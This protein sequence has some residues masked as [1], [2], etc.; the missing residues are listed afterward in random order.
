[1]KKAKFLFL[2]PAA[3][4]F[5]LWVYWIFVQ[6]REHMMFGDYFRFAGMLFTFGFAV[7]M[8]LLSGDFKVIFRFKSIIAS[9]D[10]VQISGLV[11]ALR[12]LMINIIIAGVMQT[13]YDTI[14]IIYQ[15]FGD[16]LLINM[17]IRL[18]G[19]FYALLGAMIITPFIH[20]LENYISQLDVDGK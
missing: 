11:A 15:N 5:G 6:N 8:S 7:I 3:I 14:N 9:K 12:H 1:M 18:C 16:W 19:C 4:I 17:G 20:Y 2:T 13:I 10:I